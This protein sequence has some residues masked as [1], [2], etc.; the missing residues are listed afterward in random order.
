[1]IQVRD[2]QSQAITVLSKTVTS[3][4]PF[5]FHGTHDMVETICRKE[6]KFNGYWELARSFNDIETSDHRC[7]E[8]FESPGVFVLELVR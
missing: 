4:G 1:M 5:Q 7:T 8:C 2:T 6:I 3:G